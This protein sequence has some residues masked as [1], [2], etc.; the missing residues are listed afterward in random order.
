M[1]TVD[2]FVFLRPKW[3]QECGK[4]IKRSRRG[5]HLFCGGACK[6]KA[7]RKRKKISDYRKAKELPSVV[8]TPGQPHKA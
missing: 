5:N 2:S 8:R 7:Y 1:D 6:Q 3:C 4:E